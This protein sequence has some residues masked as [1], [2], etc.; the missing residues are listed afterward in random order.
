MHK[1][2]LSRDEMRRLGYR[3]VD[4][5]VD[6]FETVSDKPAM[7][8]ASRAELEA[9][10]REPIP[11]EPT[12]F[13]DLL[14]KLEQ[15]VWLNIGHLSHPRFFAFIPSPNNFVSVMAEALAAGFNPFAGTWIE[16][17]GPA[18]IELV[19]LDWL[20]EI[21]GMPE[22]A[23]GLFVSGGS[24]ANL[25][26]LAV[27]RHVKLNDEIENAVVYC[28]DQT[29]SSI[30]RALRVLG[31]SREQF[32]RIQSDD[33]LRL[34]Q[35][36]LAE[37]VVRD[38]LAGRRPFCVIANA[39]TTNSGAIDPLNEIADYCVQENLWLHVDGSY[40]AAAALCEKGRR[41]LA[42]IERAD[43]LSLD[44][45]KWLFQPFEIGCLLV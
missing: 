6:H 19:L 35:T 22:S 30:E 41:L 29:H 20:R 9:A 33:D 40:G 18:Q 10:L 13:D 15:D 3:I 28:S 27:A 24:V 2:Q 43:S 23:G 31:F 12:G 11:E 16:G 44:P 21:C 37:A 34:S 4:N 1:L 14:D 38:R 45:H 7:R 17:S 36:Q 26:A 25:T 39:G 32:R 42:G 5:I 8:L